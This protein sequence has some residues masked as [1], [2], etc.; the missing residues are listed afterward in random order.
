MSDSR[1]FVLRDEHGV[2]H[3]DNLQPIVDFGLSLGVPSLGAQ[4][5]TESVSV[6]QIQPAD[7]LGDLRARVIP[8]T[9]YVE[10]NDLV[11]AA[12]I[13]DMGLFDEVDEPSKAAVDKAHKETKAH[14]EAMKER[15]RL[16]AAG[17]Q[18]PPDV[19][20]PTPDPAAVGQEA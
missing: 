6:V 13:S 11:I 17:E 18:E 14:V 16:V 12:A 8:N 2:D 3:A 4:G 20:D 7:E 10:T 19:N 9:R 5:F 15:D 1:Y